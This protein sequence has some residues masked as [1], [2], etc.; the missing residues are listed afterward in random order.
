MGFQVSTS[1]HPAAGAAPSVNTKILDALLA[2]GMLKPADQEAAVLYAKRRQIHVEEALIQMGLVEELAMLKFQAAHYRTLFLSTKKLSTAPIGDSLLK[3]V[4]GKLA[5][6]LCVFPVRFDARNQELS[7]LTV[8]P[9]DLELLKNVQFATRVPKVRALVA[10]PAAIQAAIKVHYDGETGA[11]GQI[12]NTGTMSNLGVDR[13]RPATLTSETSLDTVQSRDHTMGGPPPNPRESGV[14]LP[15]VPAPKRQT[16]RRT[17]AGQAPPPPPVDL[18]PVP[19]GGLGSAPPLPDPIDLPDPGYVQG[20]GMVVEQPAIQPAR[21]P[22]YTG[23]PAPQVQQPAGYAGVP[24]QQPQPPAAPAPPAPQPQQVRQA[25]Q[26]VPAAAAPKAQPPGIPIHDY[27]ETLNVLL[28]LLENDRGDLRGH[29]ALVARIARRVCERLGLKPQESDAIIIAAYLHDIGKTSAYHL[30][31]LNVGEYEAHRTQAKRSYQSPLRIFE[32]VRLPSGVNDILTHYYERFDGQGFPDR[33]TGKEIPLGARVLAIVETY[34]DL[35]GHPGNPFRKKL[36]PQ[37]AWEV[38]AKFKGKI[39]DPGLVDVF[40]LVVLGDDLRAK[41]LAGERRA[42]IIDPDPEET[43]VLELRL[44]EHGFEVTIARN[45]IEGENELTNEFDVV[46]SEVELR[47]FDGFKLLENLRGNGNAVPFVF[48]STVADSEAMQ[49][50]LDMGAD[51]YFMKPASPD[52]VALKVNRLLEAGRARAKKRTGGVSGSL[53]EMALPDVVQILFHGRKSGRLSIDA[54]GKQGEI[55]F[56]DGMIFDARF[57]P[58]HREEAF[59]EMLALSAGDFELDP[60]FRPTEQLIQMPPES[61]LL[62]GMR[63]LDESGR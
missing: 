34:A 62:E 46:I 48:L 36:T 27:L 2:E 44:A 60:N 13:E 37:E 54:A 9:D 30:T 52:V 3:L 25:P 33:L 11:F 19:G 17:I 59:Y 15:P 51:E 29:S 56:C 6:K 43:T 55:L 35:T 47:P 57:G 41:L 40:K 38:L 28:A 63:R 45:A 1:L 61:L 39:F 7:I 42:L 14:G 26:Q 50:G 58:L 16:I 24:A 23:V 31:A 5:K 21:T 20:H 18:P 12:R 49:K 8:E 53:T 22:S 32:S 4:G 10:R